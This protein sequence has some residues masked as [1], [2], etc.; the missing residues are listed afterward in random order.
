MPYFAIGDLVKVNK[1]IYRADEVDQE[2]DNEK[3]RRIDGALDIIAQEFDIDKNDII[4]VISKG[5]P[6]IPDRIFSFL[7]GCRSECLVRGIARKRILY[8]SAGDS[9]IITDL[10][11]P[12][13][14]HSWYAKVFM[15]GKIKT[16]RIT[17]LTKTTLNT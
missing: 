7:S 13:D 1:D 8:A 14:Q 4:N 2:K 15:D 10:F 5:F 3:I 9:G 12:E 11:I 17:S 6:T 16:F